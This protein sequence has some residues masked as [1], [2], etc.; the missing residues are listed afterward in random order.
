MKA[1]RLN[2]NLM[3]WS[4]SLSRFVFPNLVSLDFSATWFQKFLVSELLDFLERSPM[5]RTV[6]IK[7]TSYISLEGVPQERVVVLP[8][9]EDLGLIATTGGHGYR[10]AAHI[11]C[12]SAR[13]TSIK[14]DQVAYGVVPDEI[15]P[16]SA[17]WKTIVHQYTK[18][19][20]EEVTLEIRATSVVTCKLAFRSADAT[21]VELYSKIIGEEDDEENVPLVEDIHHKVFA[22]ATRT[23]RDHPQLASVKHLH[24]CHSY[25]SVD[26]TE[27]SHVANG[28]RQL[29]ESV[30]PLD[31]L[32]IHHCDLRPYLYSFLPEHDTEEPI[33]FPPIQKLTILHPLC[34]FDE[35]CTTGLVGLARSQHALGIPF[36]RVE[37]WN[38]GMSVEVEQSL[39]PWVGSV[40]CYYDSGPGVIDDHWDQ[41]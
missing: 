27:V 15:F 9:A 28:V 25:R 19:P 5:L 14:H 32:T 35:L 11:S 34:L 23:I 8:K 2:S 26:S 20:V 36:E 18:S 24:I 6:H 37:I 30:G 12:P 41:W 7:A 21:V 22:Q 13:S 39:R 29:F 17:L 3:W 1:F 38:K 40:E 4:P 16:P 10:V 33:V 31:E